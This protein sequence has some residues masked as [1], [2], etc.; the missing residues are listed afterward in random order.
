MPKRLNEKN[1]E[2]AMVAIGIAM[3]I[4][5]AVIGIAQIFEMFSKPGFKLHVPLFD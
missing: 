2:R 5:I 3:L 1:L 4:V